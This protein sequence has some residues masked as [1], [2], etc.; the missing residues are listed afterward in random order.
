L[1]ADDVVVEEKLDGANLGF[2]VSVAGQLQ[3]QNRGQYLVAPFSG[4]FAR[5]APWLATHEERLFDAL[6]TQLIAFGEWCAARHSLRYDALPDWWLLFDVF[7]RYEKRF[8]SVA[9]RNSWAKAQGFSV[10][11]QLYRGQVDLAKLSVWVT[12][13]ESQFRQGNLEGLVIRRESPH[14]LEARAKLVRSDFTQ[15]IDAH[16]RSRA[17]EWNQLDRP[18]KNR[19]SGQEDGNVRAQGKASSD[20]RRP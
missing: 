4:Q 15:S 13:G 8:W 20:P 6:G 12:S 16:W 1:L 11:P 5:L 3:A 2:S 14:W 10:V 9:R 7:D 18:D 17:L 19:P